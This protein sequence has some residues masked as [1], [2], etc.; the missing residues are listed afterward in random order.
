VSKNNKGYFP[1]FPSILPRNFAFE[2][3]IKILHEIV[4][5]SL[6]FITSDYNDFAYCLNVLFFIS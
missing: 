3:L 1:I 2:E 4:W 5:K 6:Q